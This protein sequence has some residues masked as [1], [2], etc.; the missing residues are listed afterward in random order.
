MKNLC[1]SHPLPVRT[2]LGWGY[3]GGVLFGWGRFRTRFGGRCLPL[4]TYRWT[5]EEPS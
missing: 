1:A 3:E 5:C 2:T 4:V